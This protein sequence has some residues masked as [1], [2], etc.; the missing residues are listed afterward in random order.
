MMRV[1]T[2]LPPAIL[3]LGTLSTVCRAEVTSVGTSGFSVSHSIETF[4]GP[5]TVY[6]AIVEDIAKWWEGDHSWSGDAAN[7]YFDARLGGC[8]CEKLPG[9]GVEHLRI[10]Y[11]A[12]AR[13]IRMQGAL[14]PLQPMGLQGTMTWKIEPSDAGSVLDWKYT[15]HGHLEGG[16][17][18]I[19][20]A[21]DGVIGAQLAGL[22]EFLAR[23]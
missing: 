18:G 5:D 10:I 20:P 1:F 17:A 9:G 19:A 3:A 21:V 15:V 13:E 11:L 8:F 12:P 4:A 22:G 6:R 7:L 2:Q 23:E 16:F 14:G